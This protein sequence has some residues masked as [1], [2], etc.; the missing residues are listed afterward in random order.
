M[1]E[2]TELKK[3]SVVIPMYNA[4]DT[5]VRAL[6]SVISQTYQGV[7]EIIVVNDGSKDNSPQIVEDF[8]SKNPQI[9]LK[10]INQLN[11]GVSK[12]RNTGLRN[13]TGEYIA[14]LDSDD[15]WYEDKLEIQLPY[16]HNNFADFVTCLRNDDIISFPYK[17]INNEYALVTTKKLL[18]KVVGQTSTAVF[19]S[20]ILSNVGYYDESQKYS[21]DA[22]Y[23]MQV[24]FK[25]KMII[26]N[27]KLVITGGGKPS[28]GHSGLSA[29]MKAMEEGVQKNIE[30][31]FKNGY[32]NKLE[33]I[34]I[35]LFSKLKYTV[36]NLRY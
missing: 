20:D 1:E 22:N 35:K 29:N 33:Y 31:M 25:N 4:K 23:W 21:E 36:R 15:A 11:G 14:L 3:I 24:A 30:E 5:I 7:L 17:L 2:N 13:A 32:I 10:L 16:L 27:K 6:N 18:I 19:K 26:L 9:N 12:A 8:I 28:V 34:L